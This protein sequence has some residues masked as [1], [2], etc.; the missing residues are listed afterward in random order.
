MEIALRSALAHD[1]EGI[2]AL[3][4]TYASRGELLPRSLREIHTTI[5]DW[6]VALMEQHVI[7]CGSLISYSPLYT[8]IRSL[9][10]LDRYTGQGIGKAL[11]NELIHMARERGVNRLFALTRAVPF[12][13]CIGFKHSP[14]MQFPEKVWRDCM[15][16]SRQDDC[17]EVAVVLSLNGESEMHPCAQ[18]HG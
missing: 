16:C 6:V 15:L 12:F 11:V 17:D 18:I 7:G 13:E 14:N 3:V 1:A 5:E 2:A 10:V 4:D 8:E 9:A